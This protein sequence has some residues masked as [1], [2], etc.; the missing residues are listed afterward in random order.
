M[1][2]NIAKNG[3]QPPHPQARRRTLSAGLC[4]AVLGT[5][6]ALPFAGGPGAGS[7]GAQSLSDPV[8]IGTA[9][10][11]G[12]TTDIHVLG[13]NDLH[14][15]LDGST[16]GTQYGRYAGGAAALGKLVLRLQAQY[17]FKTVTV[18]AGDSIGATPLTSSLFEDE[19]T[20]L[21]MNF[22]NLD[23]ASVGNHEFDRGSAHLL[24]MASGGCPE[25]ACLSPL[26]PEQRGG[27]SK[28]FLGASFTYLASNVKRADG[29]PFLPT[30]GIKKIKSDAGNELRIGVIGSVLKATPTIVTPAGVRGLVFED[31]ATAANEA[32]KALRANGA[33]TSILVIHEGGFQSPAPTKPGDC[34]G[35]LKGSSI[36]KI[37]EKLD[38][39]IRVIVSG[40]THAEYRC[41]LK[42]NGV[43]RLVTSSSSFGRILTDIT[44]TVDSVNG[45]LVAASAVNIITENSTNTDTTSRRVEDPNKNDADITALASYFSAAAAPKANR[46]VGRVSADMSNTTTNPTGEILL[47][48]VIADAQLESTKTTGKAQ[49][50]FMNP[51]GIRAPGF[52]VAQISAGEQP[53]EVTYAEAFT[54]QPFGNSL[55]TMTLTGTQI[56]SLLEQQFTGCGGQVTTRTLQVSDGFS[57]ERA[58]GGATCADK[59]GKMTFAGKDLDPAA[60]YRVTMNSFLSTGGDGFTVF[61]DGKEVIGGEIDLDALIAYFALKGTLNPGPG[62]RIIAK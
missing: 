50:A 10:V 46:V 38:P 62:N 8:R 45:E 36:E 22:M 30:Y 54:V 25:K 1:S 23:F 40:H 24:R 17:K 39:T 53:G 14:G 51:G 35:A 41:V 49:I 2:L 52:S 31:E 15:H 18:S 16:S 60:N 19:P 34:A 58:P 12:A 48:D 7:A 55:V 6:V 26:Y 27:R 37:A 3:G 9:L 11:D 43:D 56:R 20:I 42:T 47:G 59:V 13:F 5:V 44:L 4:I 32:A 33:K 21:A 28:T 29:K 57:Y 61:N